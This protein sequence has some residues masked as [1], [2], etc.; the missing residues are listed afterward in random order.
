MQEYIGRIH[1]QP[2]TVLFLN[3][4]GHGGHL[5]AQGLIKLVRQGSG[6]QPVADASSHQQQDDQPCQ[7]PHGQ[8]LAN[9]A[10]ESSGSNTYPMPRRVWISGAGLASLSLRRSDDKMDSMT[11]LTSSVPSS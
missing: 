8:A 11:L 1:L 2:P 6:C 3:E 10:H 4:H 7:Q 9:G 5:R